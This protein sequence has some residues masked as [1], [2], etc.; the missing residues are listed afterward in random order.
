M[1]NDADDDGQTG[2]V[3]CLIQGNS[4]EGWDLQCRGGMGEYEGRSQVTAVAVD[5]MLDKEARL[6][7][8]W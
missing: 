4:G 1:E 3:I 7:Q 2:G 6:S 8:S 5:V